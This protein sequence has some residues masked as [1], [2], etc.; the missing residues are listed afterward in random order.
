MSQEGRHQRRDDNRRRSVVFG[1]LAVLL[2]TVLGIGLAAQVRVN[3]NEDYLD[4]ARPA[5]LLVVLDNLG[6]REAA[7]RED[8]ATLQNTLTTLQNESGG[9]GAALA[10]ARAE[11]D[12]LSIQ[13]GAVAA[14]G[15]G[16]VVMVTDPR[17]GV[18]SEVL[19]DAVQELR[20]AGAEAIQI[21]GATGEPVRIGIDSWIAG[22][23]GNTVV[24]GRET[25]AP[26]VITAIGDPPTLS[27][28]LDIPGGVVDTVARNGGECSVSQSQQ[29]T[30]SALRDPRSR[31]YAQP[32]N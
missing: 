20:A 28:A 3:D 2:M 16:V 25:K 9:S 29:V 22:P 17:N 7:I 30:V 14:T 24:D 19:V 18:G 31:Q 8:I 1:C 5:D 12:A 21:A 26:F 15:P 23:A 11:L 10:E 27:A 13:V 6:R 4:S 32:G